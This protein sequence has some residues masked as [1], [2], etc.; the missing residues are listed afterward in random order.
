MKAKT[1]MLPP[2]MAADVRGRPVNIQ[3]TIATMKIVRRAATDERTG[4]VSDIKTRKDPEKTR[5]VGGPI[6]LL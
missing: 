1:M 4:D 6:S 2:P 3:S 5:Y